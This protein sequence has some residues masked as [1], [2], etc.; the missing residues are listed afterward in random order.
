MTATSTGH[1][2]AGPGKENGQG[3]TKPNLMAP[4]TRRG[5]PTGSP[6]VRSPGLPAAGSGSRPSRLSAKDSRHVVPARR[7]AGSMPAQDLPHRGC[8]DRMPQL[9]QF[10]LDPPMT[11]GRVLPR[12]PDDQRLDRSAGGR[13]SWPAPAGVVPLAGK[14]VTVPAQDRGRGDREDP[15]HWRRF[16]SRDSAA[17]RAGRHSGPRG[18]TRPRR[19]LRGHAGHDAASRDQGHR[20]D[21]RCRR[22][23]RHRQRRVPRHR[24]AHP[25]AADHH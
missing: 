17:S 12:H 4:G 24:P 21:R 22:F 8:R 19:G 7:G 16:T 23:S 14:E 5:S 10:A 18:R 6:A 3:I 2:P 9:R 13:P 11:P 15:G 20:R 25:I 1:R